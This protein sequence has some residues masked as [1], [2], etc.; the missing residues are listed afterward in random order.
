[1]KKKSAKKGSSKK[2]TSKLPKRTEASRP[3]KVGGRSATPGATWAK[4]GRR[5][6]ETEETFSQLGIELKKIREDQKISVS[7]LAKDLEVAPATLIKFEDRGY[8]ISIKVV[9][10]MANRLGYTLKLSPVS[11]GT[12]K[13]KK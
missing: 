12:R 9:S 3:P 5:K 8:P 6:L 1:M 10:A 4:L 13:K 7:K 11:S 2:A